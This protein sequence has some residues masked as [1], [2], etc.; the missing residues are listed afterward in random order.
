[1]GYRSKETPADKPYRTNQHYLRAKLIFNPIAGQA[2]AKPVQLTD[3]IHE[4]QA[5]KIIPEIYLIEP[6]SDLPAVIREALGRGIRLFV[7]CGGD[8]TITTAA[9]ALARTHPAR[10]LTGINAALGIIPTGTQNDTALSLGIPEDAASAVALLRTGKRI[11][12]DVGIVQRGKVRMPFLEECSVGLVSTLF[13]SADDIQHGDLTRIA[14]FLATLA[15]APPAEIRLKL[16]GR[17]ELHNKGHVALVCNM[18]YI[19]LHYR[20]SPSASF[21]DGL[22]DVLS[23]GDLSKLDLLSYIFQVES[24]GKPTDPRI[25]HYRVRTVEIDT[26]P[27]MPVMVD[28]APF[29]EGALRIEVRRRAL[30]VMVSQDFEEA[31]QGEGKELV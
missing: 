11:S 5:W 10:T 22:L 15:A 14:D 16:D 28:G 30:S 7:V 21:S 8:G 23:F 24:L 19:G 18:P 12:V 2:R 1:M 13:P 4:M 3:V 25:Q 9:R 26:Q 29:G 17:Q 6:G 31:Y 27:R 20:V